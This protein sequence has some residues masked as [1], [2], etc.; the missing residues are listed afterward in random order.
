MYFSDNVTFN[1]VTDDG[2]Q[3]FFRPVNSTILH[4]NGWT[5][6]FG[7]TWHLQGATPYSKQFTLTPGLYQVV[8]DWGN[9]VGFGLSTFLV[10]GAVMNSSVWN[11]TGWNTSSPLSYS[12]PHLNRANPLSLPYGVYKVATGT[13]TQEYVNNGVIDSYSL[14]PTSGSVTAGSNNTIAFNLTSKT[15]VNTLVEKGLPSG[16]AWRAT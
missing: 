11:V 6:A 4:S 3:V 16:Y 1:I 12:L 15:A 9:S 7:D 2:M 8:V 13:W 14:T 10:S 5:T